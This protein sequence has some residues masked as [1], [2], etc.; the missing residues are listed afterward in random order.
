M[1]RVSKLT[2]Y[3]TV[4]LT[5]LAQEGASVRTAEELAKATRINSPTAKKTLKLLAQGGLVISVRGA[6]GGYRLAKDPAEISMA[7]II[8]A[9]EG[10]IAL[11]EC[12]RH[13]GRCALESGCA[14]RAPW[15]VVN[16]AVH[17]T[18][19]RLHLSDLSQPTSLKFLAA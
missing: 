19:H 2:D 6:H 9:I 1:L 8:E 10:P 5:A 4:V 3:G 7:D 11:T 15:Q 13:A 17:A 16:A 18:L 12:A 14:I